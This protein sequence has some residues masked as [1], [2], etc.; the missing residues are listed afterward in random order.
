M[1]HFTD[2][3]HPA[4]SAGAYFLGAVIVGLILHFIFWR[5]V[6]GLATR[7]TTVLDDSLMRHCRHPS[8]YIFPILLLHFAMPFITVGLPETVVSFIGRAITVVL[9]LL[10]AW[11]LIRLGN[12]L[13]DLIMQHRQVDIAD[14]LQ[15]RRIQTQM[16]IIKKVINLLVTVL[17]L[18]AI[19]MSFE[20]VRQLGAGLLAS[21]GLAGLVIGLAAQRTLANLL[22]GI[23][24]AITQPIRLDDVVI[25]ENE[26]GW[27]EEITLTYVVVR[28][29]DLRR[30]V[31]PISYFIEKPFQNWTR[32]SAD[33]LG[34][35][36]LHTDYTVP[37]DAIREELR[38]IVE[39]SDKWD[40]KVA[41]VVVTDTS[42]QAMEVRALI[43][44]AN[45]SNAWDLRCEVR[46]K[47]VDF[48][49]KN[50]PDSLPRVRAEFHE[51]DSG[52][53]GVHPSRNSE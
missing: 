12:V 31:L 47:L 37:L 45:S 38:R 25:V 35:I 51:R 24:I 15:A 11:L 29:W 1:E 49:H 20:Q 26:W 5:A 36:Y 9:I 41:S 4:L 46:E 2:D 10:V 19:L 52:G 42:P 7:T 17:A 50:Y 30:L 44:A 13:E 33:I 34:T 39:K 27:I 8:L 23:Q 6:R 3:W 28:I 18:G 16:Q 53:R 48:M 14:N 43:S 21:A 22:A 32:T 40:G